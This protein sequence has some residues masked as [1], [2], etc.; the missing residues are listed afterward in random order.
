[1]PAGQPMTVSVA[2]EAQV[3]ALLAA[4]REMPS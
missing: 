2:G 3:E 1:M 4:A